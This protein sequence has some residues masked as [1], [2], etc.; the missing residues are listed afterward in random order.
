MGIQILYTQKLIRT[1]AHTYARTHIYNHCLSSSD[2][3]RYSEKHTANC[4]SVYSS[5]L[6]DDSLVGTLS[7]TL[8]SPLDF[9]SLVHIT[10]LISQPSGRTLKTFVTTQKYYCC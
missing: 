10:K 2:M 1:P 3:S 7:I 5:P 6:L 9:T 8:T 4:P